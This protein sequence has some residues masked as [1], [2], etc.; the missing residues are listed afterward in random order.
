MTKYLTYF[1]I[2]DDN[3]ILYMFSNSIY[4]YGYVDCYNKKDYTC[5]ICSNLLFRFLTTNYYKIHNNT[6]IEISF[7][8]EC[9]NGHISRLFY[10]LDSIKQP[11]AR[12]RKV[13][14]V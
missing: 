9:F 8:V 7:Q 12:I 14:I 3:K 4:S 11:I 2:K 6:N 10:R 1:D 13:V 5:G